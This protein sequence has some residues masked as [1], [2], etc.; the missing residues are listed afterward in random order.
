MQA[1][2]DDF[3][4]TG[5]YEFKA[6]VPGPLCNKF[7]VGKVFL[8]AFKYVGINISQDSYKITL[9]QINYIN[10]IKLIPISCDWQ[11]Q[12]H[13]KCNDNESIPY[14]LLVGKLNWVANQSRP[15]IC[16]DVCQ[17]KLTMKAQVVIDLIKANKVLQ[18]I[19]N[20]PLVLPLPNLRNIENVIIKY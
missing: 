18:K 5:S 9:D 6:K 10:S 14:C 16:F 20:N 17:L 4:W 11:F 19:K 13:G 2:A 3:I 12:N 1:H 7:Q 8:K 15:H